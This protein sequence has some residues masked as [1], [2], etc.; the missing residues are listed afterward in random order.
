[1]G[2]EKVVVE[3]D[4]SSRRAYLLSVKNSRQRR[5][6][7]AIRKKEEEQ[8]EI[9]RN[10]RRQRKERFDGMAEEMIE[11]QERLGIKPLALI[12]KMEDTDIPSIVVGDK[13]EEEE[14]KHE[15]LE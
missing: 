2:K 15:Q 5:K 14:P 13:A 3:F 10:L 6:E 11:H 12:K 4:E 8:R 1:M 7:K 9:R